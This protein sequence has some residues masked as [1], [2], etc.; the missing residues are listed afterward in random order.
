VTSRPV[1]LLDVDGVINA[2]RAGWH[3]A[4][5]SIQVYSATDKQAYRIRWEPRLIA[6]IRRIHDTDLADVIWSTTWCPDIAY[7]EAALRT[8]EYEVAFRVRP[9]HLTW[10]ELKVQA[11][12][13]ALDEGRRVIWTD[14]VEVDVARDMFPQIAAA[15]KAG[16]ALLIAPH[17]NRGLRPEDLDRIETFC[18][19]PAARRAG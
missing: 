11:V 2:P 19:E 5:R 4:P 6:A 10:A 14:D 17:P 15:E 8:G 12:L 9:S 7:L 13:D 16:R 18:K 3:R 1:W